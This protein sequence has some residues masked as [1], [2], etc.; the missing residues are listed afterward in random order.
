MATKKPN[1]PPSDFE[2]V[3]DK[4][5]RDVDEVSQ[6]NETIGGAKFQ[7]VVETWYESEPG[8]RTPNQTIETIDAVISGYLR[9]TGNRLANLLTMAETLANKAQAQASEAQALSSK[10]AER[11]DKAKVASENLLITIGQPQAAIEAFQESIREELK[12]TQARKL[13]TESAERAKGAYIISWVGLL[14][15]LIGAPV[16]AIVQS[17]AIFQF[18]RAIGDAVLV[19]LPENATET[20]ILIAAV[21]RLVLVTLPVALFVWLIRII[22]RFNMRSL[23]LM[24]DA[25]QR[26]TMLETYLHL[27]EQDATVKVDRPLILEALF[28]RTPGHGAETIEPP[29]FADILKIGASKTS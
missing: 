17:E 12:L 6:P 11:V 24:D 23:L 27:V 13:W 7:A 21:S 29:N 14:I 1:D 10:V 15:L 25:R 16:I 9:T 26:N 18:F 2:P 22:V 5:R 28:R 8:E 19:D 3:F 20:A 4:F